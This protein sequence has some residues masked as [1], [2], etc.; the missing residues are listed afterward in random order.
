MWKK[1]QTLTNRRL[2]FSLLFCLFSLALGQLDE[3]PAPY[4]DLP[5]SFE[6][7]E[8]LE[9]QLTQID[10]HRFQDPGWRIQDSENRNVQ[11]RVDLPADLRKGIPG[12]YDIL[13]T[14]YVADG[15]VE[16]QIVLGN[17]KRKAT[18]IDTD[19]CSVY[20]HTCSK[21]ATCV[22]E[23]ESYSCI[24]NPGFRGNGFTCSNV[25]ECA[26]GTHNCSPNAR[27]VDTHGSYKCS[28]LPGFRGDGEHCND[29]NECAEGTHDCHVNAHC[30][31][32]FGSF[33]CE[34]NDG[35][36]GDGKH[37]SIINRCERGD[38][39][40]D[41]NADCVTLSEGWRCICHN[42]WRGDGVNC[43]EI[44]ECVE[45]SGLCG[46][47]SICNNTPGSYECSCVE[48]F[49]RVGNQCV[50]INECAENIDSCSVNGECINVEGSYRCRCK[51]G[52]IGDG[53]AC[54]D[55]AEARF[56]LRGDERM[57]I[58]QFS[59]YIEPGLE[60]INDHTAV[61]FLIDIPRQLDGYAIHCGEFDITY[62]VKF[63]DDNT[64]QA[65]KRRTVVVTPTNQCTLPEDSLFADDCHPFA[66]CIHFE[67]RCTY[68]CTCPSGY[69]GDGKGTNGCIDKVPP[70][71]PYQGPNPVFRT[72]CLVCG[73]FVAEVDIREPVIESAYDPTP[74]GHVNVSDRI[75][76]DY[77]AHSNPDCIDHIYHV[78]D[79][80]GNEATR[81]LTVCIQREDMR[82]IIYEMKNMYDWQMFMIKS[83][84]YGALIFLVIIVVYE[85]GSHIAAIFRVFVL[86]NITGNPPFWGDF[87]IAYT[88]IYTLLHPTYAESR[89]RALVYKRF[90]DLYESETD[91]DYDSDDDQELGDT[92][93]DQ[94]SDEE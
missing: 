41:H 69:I 25:D 23:V 3:L 22:D 51:D 26:E 60:F 78:T 5:F 92:D 88:I 54:E 21:F 94:E 35:Y 58:P 39:N 80:A 75:R 81:R 24:C 37:C 38:H 71:I 19:V 1:S 11:V 17:A 15:N 70:V 72:T 64:V 56:A 9:L 43:K 36:Y 63:D 65:Q 20:G 84:G 18:L 28:C 73:E 53:F 46:P 91:I 40:C 48:G 47:Y 52:Y 74:H 13:Y 55:T 32:T 14:A 8:P 12:H 42:G 50:D 67:H 82:S 16:N 62:S 7:R 4:A 61:S 93:T 66:Q 49:R 6:L 2:L 31:N 27:C 77:E 85:F 76:V 90:T 68:E 86:S 87:S 29:I 59:E 44:D 57:Y 83:V 10:Y 45:Q 33:T 89:I 30:Q 79:Y 34:C